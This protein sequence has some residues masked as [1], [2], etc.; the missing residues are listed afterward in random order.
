MSST[1]KIAIILRAPSGM[2]K[3][4]VSEIIR[5]RHPATRHISLD[6]GWSQGEHR[7]VGG[8]SRYADLSA[9]QENIL[10]VELGWG[11]PADRGSPGAT[12][13]ACEWVTTL[14][15]A[16]RVIVPFLLWAD[17]LEVDARL[18]DREQRQNRP[19][20][21]YWVG[22]GTYALYEHRH[23]HYS[24]PVIPNFFEMRIDTTGRSHR[25]VAE[26]IMSVVGILT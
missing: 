22:M 8:P 26:F 11:E 2:G 24:Y 10:I 13:G 6:D 23:P 3:S 25:E 1:Q 9:V 12:R 7:Y 16:G 17:C 19:P 21:E 14:R 20:Q 4:R 18:R 5:E 15:T